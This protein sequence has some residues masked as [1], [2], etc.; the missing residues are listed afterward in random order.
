VLHL[1][2]KLRYFQQ[3]EWPADWIDTAKEIVRS[4]YA[5]YTIDG[6]SVT[7]SLLTYIDDQLPMGCLQLVVKDISEPVDFSDIPMANIEK[8]NEL[9][10]YLSQAI[11]KVR[12]PLA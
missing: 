9:D 12:D 11:E 3:C 1:Q 8:T 5:K 2:L 4:A 6:D 10:E 7:V